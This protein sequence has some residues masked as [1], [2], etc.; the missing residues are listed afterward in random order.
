MGTTT[1]TTTKA[2]TEPL[3][4]QTKPPTTEDVRQVPAPSP[5]EIIEEGFCYQY[6]L[7]RVA[8]AA[9]CDD[10]A[11]SLNLDRS[12]DISKSGKPGGCLQ[13]NDGRLKF[14]SELDSG[15]PSVN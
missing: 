15:D 3:K 6:G 8:D 12:G 11:N 9:M 4:R 1:T 7:C 10:A 2:T 5:Y 13:W 14:N